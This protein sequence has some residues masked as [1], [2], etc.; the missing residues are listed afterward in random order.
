MK[1]ITKSDHC[2]AV[3]V[4]LGSNLHRASS[5]KLAFPWEYV[6]HGR[7]EHPSLHFALLHELCMVSAVLIPVFLH[8]VDYDYT[9]QSQDE[10][11]E[12]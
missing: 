7:G 6:F 5:A 4:F 9:L 1:N 10:G 2:T 3:Q 12:W 8:H 11:Y